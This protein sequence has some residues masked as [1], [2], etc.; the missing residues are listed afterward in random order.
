MKSKTLKLGANPNLSFQACAGHL[1]IQSWD[2][3]DVQLLSSGEGAATQVEEVSGGLTITGMMPE[4]VNVPP[5]A[6]VL[7]QS[8][9]GDVHATDLA[10]LRIERHQGDLA[11]QGV[12][13]IELTTV[14]GDVRASEAQSL[15]VNTLHGDLQAHAVAESLTIAVVHGDIAVKEAKGQLALH[16]ITGDV[17]IRN[18]VGAL[19]ARNVTGDL[20]LSGDLQ[21][22][23]YHL[24]ALGDVSLHLATTSSVH[25]ELEARLGD[26]GCDLALTETTESPHKLSGKMGQGTAEIHVVTYSGDVRLHPLGADQVRHELEKERIRTE[27]HARRAAEHA[28]R[29]VEKEIRLAEAHARRTAERAERIA[30][31]ARRASERA[32]ERMEE[33]AARMQR[34]QVKRAGQQSGTS[35]EALENERLAILKMLAEGKI[36]TEQAEG[37]LE[38]LEG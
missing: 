10:S 23:S 25:L 16:D 20:A 5:A 17:A 12:K 31:R 24:E 36:N 9:A 6:S 11:L 29:I 26:I 38:A 21:T 15:Q 35:P 22:G 8:C 3:E 27:A 13:R 1:R 19:D 4:M 7:L 33:R 32:A 18:P 37:L 14:H 28:Q 30:E 34:W 2:L